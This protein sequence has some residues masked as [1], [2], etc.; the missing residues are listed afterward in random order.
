MVFK[1]VRIGDG[2]ILQTESS[3]KQAE[4]ALWVLNA[5][6]VKYGRGIM[7]KIEPPLPT[8]T[9]VEALPLPSWAVEALRNEGLF[10]ERP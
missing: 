2:K 4:Y 5:H 6:E 3:P 8:P 1:I 10:T 7:Y 9:P